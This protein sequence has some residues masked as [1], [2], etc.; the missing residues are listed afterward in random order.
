MCVYER[1]DALL[2]PHTKHTFWF[3]HNGLSHR[4]CCDFAGTAG[5]QARW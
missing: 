1:G 5:A 3:P 4:L 2:D